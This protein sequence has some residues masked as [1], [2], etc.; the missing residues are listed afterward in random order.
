M[1]CWQAIVKAHEH[2]ET[3]QRAGEVVELKSITPPACGPAHFGLVVV[4]SRCTL[5]AEP[6]THGEMSKAER[7]G[8][9]AKNCRAKE[10]QRG[11]MADL[12]FKA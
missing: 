8:R 3:T 2:S 4:V 7:G 9:E 6:V 10:W 12:K 11:S 5:Q 1:I